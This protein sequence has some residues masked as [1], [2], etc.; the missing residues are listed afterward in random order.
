MNKF[1]V[2]ESGPVRNYCVFVGHIFCEMLVIAR[3]GVCRRCSQHNVVPERSCAH[4]QKVKGAGIGERVG[5]GE[6]P[7]PALSDSELALQ[8]Q[9]PTYVHS[10]LTQQNTQGSCTAVSLVV[11]QKIETLTA[12][13]LGN[14]VYTTAA[15]KDRRF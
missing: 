8:P 9:C 11:P 6:S 7:G 1:Q 15:V 12:M 3:S 13:I 10:S 5:E 2:S 4:L 14:G